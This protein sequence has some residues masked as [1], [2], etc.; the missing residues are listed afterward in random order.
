[1]ETLKK[2]MQDKLVL[3]NTKLIYK[4]IKDC[5]CSWKTED[6]FQDYYDA[7]LI[8][9]INGAK[10]YDSTK[11]KVSTYLYKCIKQEIVKYF[12][13]SEFNCRKINKLDKVSL[14]EPVYDENVM[15]YAEVIP[16]DSVDIEEEIEKKIKLE[17]IIKCLEFI[18]EKD[19]VVIKKYFGLDGNAPMSVPKIAKEFNVSKNMINTRKN[20]GIRMIK[21][22]IGKVERMLFMEEKQKVLPY[23][24]TTTIK[25][26]DYKAIRF[27]QQAKLDNINYM[28]DQTNEMLFEQMKRLRELDTSK[29]E[30]ASVEIQRGNA[31]SNASKTFLQTI[32]IQM[33]IQKQRGL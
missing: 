20:R 30:Q 7:G 8:G 15:T 28:L 27:E 29:K 13:T 2:H 10:T 24:E 23:K 22:H 19:A 32:G 3:D 26:E 11:A 16:D 14:D 31:L 1:M 12:Y 33:A 18:N 21:K 5:N 9:L 6:E 4:C 25:S 17:T